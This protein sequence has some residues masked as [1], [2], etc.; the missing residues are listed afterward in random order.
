M[1]KPP[2]VVPGVS[3]KKYP[4]PTRTPDGTLG[5]VAVLVLE[6]VRVT[7]L[8]VVVDVG[9]LYLGKYLIPVFGHVDGAPTGSTG[10]NVPLWTE[11]RTL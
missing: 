1:R 3:I 8:M 5:R 4:F 9:V 10:T 7:V 6:D 11:P 2:L